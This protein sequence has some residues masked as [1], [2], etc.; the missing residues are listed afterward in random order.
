MDE[1]QSSDFS[2][3]NEATPDEATSEILSVGEGQDANPNDRDPS[4][5]PD[6]ADGMSMEEAIAA[7]KATETELASM[8]E[9]FL[10]ARAETEN[11]RRQAKEEIEKSRKFAV[12]RFASDLLG[13]KDA[14]ELALSTQNASFEQLREG[15]Q[16][17]LKQLNSAFEKARIVETDPTG[18]PFDPHLHQA[19]QMVEGDAPANTVVSVFQKGYLISERVLRPA[20]VTVSSGGKK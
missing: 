16:L 20:M 11:A 13:V 8:R 12:E 5:D 4:C 15:V 19:V 17:T 7:L 18:Q 6:F 14:L 3:D 10:R 2:A 9:A 1:R